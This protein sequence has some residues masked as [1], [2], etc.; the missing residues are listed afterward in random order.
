MLSTVGSFLQ[1]LQNED[2]GIRTAAIFTA[3]IYIY[4]FPT[5]SFSLL[6]NLCFVSL[7]SR[8]LL[9]NKWLVFTESFIFEHELYKKMNSNG[10]KRN[11]ISLIHVLVINF[12]NLAPKFFSEKI[13]VT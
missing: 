7:L 10:E 6:L 1:D 4:V 12:I 2:K 9:Y 3:G 11:G 8:K 13:L 5:L